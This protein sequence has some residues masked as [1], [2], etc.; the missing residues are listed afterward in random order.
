MLSRSVMMAELLPTETDDDDDDEAT[1][2]E[3]EDSASTTARNAVVVRVRLE[4]PREADDVAIGPK[5]A[6]PGTDDDDDDAVKNA[7]RN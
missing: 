7:K 5:A 6:A 2:T 4:R 3:E 1:A